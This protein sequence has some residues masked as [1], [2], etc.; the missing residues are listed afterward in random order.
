METLYKDFL[1]GKLESKDDPV[2]F[3]RGNDTIWEES[4]NRPYPEKQSGDLPADD[5]ATGGFRFT[6]N[7]EKPY[8]VAMSNRE[9]RQIMRIARGLDRP[10]YAEDTPDNHFASNVQNTLP[11]EGFYDVALHGAETTAEFFGKTIDAYTLAQIIRERPDYRPGEP[12]R[13]LSCST[14]ATNTTGNCF[15]QILANELNTLVIAPN[16][17]LFVNPDGS[18]YVSDDKKGDFVEFYSRRTEE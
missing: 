15:A 4:A 13:L 10:I 18:V 9:R 3:P 7:P 12:I 1:E 14:G 8:E 2:T 17:T 16:D 11:E 6:D 5:P